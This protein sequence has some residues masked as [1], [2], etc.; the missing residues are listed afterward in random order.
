MRD[1]EASVSE[2]V[3]GLLNPCNVQQ[4]P[5]RLVIV[6]ECIFFEICSES[7][8]SRRC[9]ST[10][11]ARAAVEEH[12][13]PSCSVCSG[14]TNLRL[15][16]SRSCQRRHC[17]HPVSNQRGECR[18]DHLGDSARCRPARSSTIWGR[19]TAHVWLQ[20]AVDELAKKRQY[21]LCLL[22]TSPSPR[23]S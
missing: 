22:Y 2:I 18:T 9:F 11:W 5:L 19:C 4:R 20:R 12:K 14:S 15:V 1:P 10:R 23:D 21:K 17:W 6:E 7:L 3:E 8:D 13:G 16:R